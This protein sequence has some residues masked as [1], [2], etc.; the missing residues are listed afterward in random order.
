M[1]SEKYFRKVILMGDHELKKKKQ[2]RLY[3]K[4]LNSFE[5]L[6]SSELSD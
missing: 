3:R 2:V 5:I 1:S 4:L 6:P